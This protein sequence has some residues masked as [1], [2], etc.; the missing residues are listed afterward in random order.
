VSQAIPQLH[1][2]LTENYPAAAAKFF[3]ADARDRIAAKLFTHSTSEEQVLD[4]IATACWLYAHDHT[5][6]HTPLDKQ[7]RTAGRIA[8]TAQSL[9]ILLEDAD[10]DTYRRIAMAMGDQ[11]GKVKH[12]SKEREREYRDSRYRMGRSV[13]MFLAWRNLEKLVV[14]A[15]R[16]ATPDVPSIVRPGRQAKLTP[17]LERSLCHVLADIWCELHGQDFVAPA[18]ETR[19]W[20]KRKGHDGAKFLGAVLDE[21]AKLPP[22]R[23]TRLPPDLNRVRL[24]IEVRD[25]R[26]KA[27]KRPADE[28][29]QYL[30]AS[31]SRNLDSRG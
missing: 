2:T 6:T 31:M 12:V 17:L 29:D 15:G 8:R 26:T 10:R 7:R 22:N 28:R 23:E 16:A 13:K 24:Y 1:P 19:D 27:G 5:F 4:R 21:L 11:A 30:W 18:V 20:Y 3:D 25:E 9:L 14:A